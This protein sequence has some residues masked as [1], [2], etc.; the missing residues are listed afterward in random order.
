MQ[1]LKRSYNKRSQMRDAGET[2]MMQLAA[3]HY[4]N[5]NER[6]NEEILQK[7]ICQSVERD[8]KDSTDFKDG[9]GILDPVLTYCSH[10]SDDLHQANNDAQPSKRVETSHK[11]SS[12]LQDRRCSRDKHSVFAK[13]AQL[14]AFRRQRH[15]MSARVV[16][17]GGG[18]SQAASCPWSVWSESSTLFVVTFVQ[19][20]FGLVT[21]LW[22][23]L[24]IP[25]RSLQV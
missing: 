24:P 4:N 5:N 2:R 21:I 12:D 20:A 22:R 3:S 7:K 15:H 14:S 8:H 11:D 18:H 13:V 6:F 9:G 19:K 16:G 1:K 25:A 17:S 10:E 23:R